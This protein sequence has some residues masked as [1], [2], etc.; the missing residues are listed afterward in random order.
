M[1]RWRHL[2]PGCVIVYGRSRRV[3]RRAFVICARRTPFPRAI[4]SLRGFSLCKLGSCS[5]IAEGTPLLEAHVLHIGRNRLAVI[6]GLSLWHVWYT[7][8]EGLW[9]SESSIRK[10]VQAELTGL[11]FAI[12]GPIGSMI[13][14]GS[15]NA[16]KSNITFSRAL[17]RL[18]QSF[19]YHDLGWQR[20]AD[21]WILRIPFADEG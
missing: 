2:V 21:S 11:S 6:I 20:F 14:N 7:F 15:R 19:P 4:A 1:K 18:V 9:L 8:I 5:L 3:L 17:H 13:S 12:R 10:L 16:T